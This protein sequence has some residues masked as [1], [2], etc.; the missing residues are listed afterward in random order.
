MTKIISRV[1]ILSVVGAFLHGCTSLPKSHCDSQ[2]P[3]TTPTANF[4]INWTYGI[5]FDRKTKLTWKICAEGQSFD[6][7]YC[8]GSAT[9]YTWDGA[10][11]TFG[12]SG[13]GWRLPTATELNGIVEKRCEAPT[14]NDAVFPSTSPTP[15]W[16][17]TLNEADAG[18]A[19]YVDFHYGDSYSASILSRH[20]VRLVRGE[21]AKVVEE[22]QELLLEL[23][24]QSTTEELVEKE[25]DAEQRA[26]V[27]CRNK[28]HCDKLFSLTLSYIAS[29]TGKKMELVT[30][31]LIRSPEPI[32]IGDIGM[33]ATMTS[34]SANAASIRLTVTCKPF[35]SDTIIDNLKSETEAWEKLKAKMQKSKV[36]CLSKKLSV[37]TDF[38]SFVADD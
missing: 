1:V 9:E 13:T 32:E 10:M 34:S 38:R 17:S 28:A 36:A 5:A 21:D 25:K 27:S 19:R 37:Y 2:V 31:R 7:G 30:D 6:G 20:K 23:M 35:G 29:E 22:R 3:E 15:F 33:S 16:S 11:Q 24:T 14:I 12:D 4:D 26:I 8:T 18:K